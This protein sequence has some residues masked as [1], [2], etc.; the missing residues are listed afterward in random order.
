MEKFKKCDYDSI[1]YDRALANNISVWYRGPN[2]ANKVLNKL[3]D[4]LDADD[5]FGNIT[6]EESVK[7][8]TYIDAMEKAQFEYAS[9]M[10]DKLV[11][12]SEECRKRGLTHEISGSNSSCTLNE[13]V[14]SLLET[15]WYDK[16]EVD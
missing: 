12:S 6:E 5:S 1:E 7:R 14:C 11:G 16:D 4:D 2:A 3:Y 10:A 8:R 9:N 15:A 13:D